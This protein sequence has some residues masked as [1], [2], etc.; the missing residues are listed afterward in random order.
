MKLGKE[1]ERSRN[2]YQL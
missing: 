2:R 1:E